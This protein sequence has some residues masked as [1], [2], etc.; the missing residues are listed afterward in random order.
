MSLSTLIVQQ[1]GKKR[2]NILIL[3]LCYVLMATWNEVHCCINRQSNFL[4]CGSR[5][6]IQR[7]I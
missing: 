1:E 7:E 6:Y 2:E 3:A 5:S 4:P